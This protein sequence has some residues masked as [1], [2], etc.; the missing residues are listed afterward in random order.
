MYWYWFWLCVGVVLVLVLVWWLALACVLGFVLALVLALV[1][2]WYR[3]P[4][5]GSIWDHLVAFG[6]HS[7]RY[8]SIWGHVAASALAAPGTIWQ[9][10]APSGTSWHHLV[11]P[12]ERSEPWSP[13]IKKK[14]HFCETI[15]KNVFLV[16]DVMIVE[17]TC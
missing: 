13:Q 10:L 11:F 15:N 6:T 1:F 5:S 2:V 12:A 7:A 16:R 14:H 9:H 17:R 4:A 8:S 3:Q